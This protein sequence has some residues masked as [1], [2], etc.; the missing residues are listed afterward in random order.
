MILDIVVVENVNT[1]GKTSAACESICICPPCAHP[2]LP[3]EAPPH[4]R[5]DKTDTEG[6]YALVSNN[7]K[8]GNRKKLTSL[9]F[10]EITK[11]LTWQNR[12]SP[13][14]EEVNCRSGTKC[15]SL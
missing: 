7:S 3:W 10:A 4:I 12:N 6:G 8:F 11:I 9:E 14:N 13:S 2:F 15:F 1:T 5:N